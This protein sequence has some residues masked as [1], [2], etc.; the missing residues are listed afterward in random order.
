MKARAPLRSRPPLARAALA[1]TLLARCGDAPAPA[2]PSPLA[3]LNER[4]A[5]LPEG[6]DRWRCVTVGDDRSHAPDDMPD[7]AW[8]ALPASN[9]VVYVRATA[10]VGGDGSRARPFADLASAL[11]AP[12]GTTIVLA[13]G[14]HALTGP[15][16]IADARVIVGAGTDDAGSSLALARA[17][18]GLVVEGATASLTLAG[19]RVEY[20]ATGG[21]D[22]PREIALRARG[23]ARLTLRSVLVTGAGTA[24]IVA[25]GEGTVLDGDRVT[26]REGAGN[27]VT[28][29]DGAR[30]V[31]RRAV[32]FENAATGVYVEGAHLHLLTGLLA[33]N[34]VGGAQYRGAG[35]ASGGATSCDGTDALAGGP[36]DCVSEVSITCNG[37]S[38]LSVSGA[39]TV[40]VRRS[41]IA[42]SRASDTRSGDGVSVLDGARV[43][44]DADLSARDGPAQPDLAMGTR[45]LA[46]QRAGIVVSGAGA[47]LDLRGTVV[48]DNHQGGVIVQRGASLQTMQVARIANNVAVGL[49]LAETTG[50]ASITRSE[51]TGTR[52]GAFQT[53]RGMISIGDGLSMA[54]SSGMRLAQSRFDQNGR[55]G[56]LLRGASASVTDNLGGGNRFGLGNYDPVA[57]VATNN[58][59]G[60][61]EPSPAAAPP[62][63]TMRE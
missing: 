43:T 33:G 18:G 40:D 37:I 49:A 57:V 20:A 16:T 10:P 30:G 9:P 50:F 25:E 24:G 21:R 27:G 28:M 51:F 45:V 54:A 23:G 41:A 55:F 44:L 52:A 6:V 59:V 4:R 3:P 60:G 1:V 12:A 8:L 36:T 32:A 7:P 13:R 26:V 39:R 17:A 61:R 47:S 14:R 5:S 19:V 35:D 58:M 46:N 38:G 53:D 15:L 56:V 42:D 29:L 62:V 34:A 48:A 2:C 31:L 22:V 11:R 63:A